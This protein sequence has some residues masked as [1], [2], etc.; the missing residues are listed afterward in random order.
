MGLEGDEARMTR[1]DVPLPAS[2]RIYRV[3]V[4][5]SDGDSDGDVDLRSRFDGGCDS[6]GTRLGFSCF[7][8]QKSRVF[9][10]CSHATK[11][12]WAHSP[13][14]TT[15]LGSLARV[16]CRLCAA[17]LGRYARWRGAVL[18]GKTGEV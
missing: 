17:L 18:N 14:T 15:Y 5:D 16:G 9:L 12:R 11:G 10:K 7:H 1:G 8:D 6:A 4:V 3:P 13:G 2:L